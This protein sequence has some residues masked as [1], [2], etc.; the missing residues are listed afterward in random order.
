MKEMLVTNCN[1]AFSPLPR[2]KKTKAML[3]KGRRQNKG[4]NHQLL[5]Y[6]LHVH[7]H[8]PFMHYLHMSMELLNEFEKW[9]IKPPPPIL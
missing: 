4:Q 9:Y 2:A 6:E 3:T 7:N 5:Q 1:P 8:Q